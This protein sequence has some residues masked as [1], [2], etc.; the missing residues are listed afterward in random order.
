MLTALR[1]L[2]EEQKMNFHYYN[3]GFVGISIDETTTQCDVLDILHVFAESN[4]NG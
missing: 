1:K 3:D 4:R 2:A